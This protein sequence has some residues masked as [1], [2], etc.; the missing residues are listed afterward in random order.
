[1]IKIARKSPRRT[2]VID[3]EIT[4][5]MG[6]VD[7]GGCNLIHHKINKE[8]ASFN[9][10]RQHLMSSLTSY[11]QSGI[12]ILMK[13]KK[14][15]LLE[16]IAMQLFHNLR[17]HPSK[18]QNHKWLPL[19]ID[20]LRLESEIDALKKKRKHNLKSLKIDGLKLE[21]ETDSSSSPG[22]LGLGRF[23]GVAR[24]TPGYNQMPLIV[25]ACPDAGVESVERRV[26]D[27]V[28]KQRQNWK[29]IKTIKI[30]NTCTDNGVTYNDICGPRDVNAVVVKFRNDCV[31]MTCAFNLLK[32]WITNYPA[33]YV[34]AVQMRTIIG[35]GNGGTN[36]GHLFQFAADQF[37]DAGTLLSVQHML[38]SLSSSHI[39]RSPSASMDDRNAMETPDAS[40]SKISDSEL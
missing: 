11:G 5:N 1:M 3:L 36:L 6:Y 17:C 9:L 35:G 32:I 2:W 33:E 26:F 30:G 12:R 28:T 40:E 24:A 39:Q 8:G 27:K 10:S 25:E 23:R 22:I 18:I 38:S 7:Y 14:I 37:S 16:V 15:Y 13:E 21:C 31:N 4:V 29:M 20:D 34:R 19:K